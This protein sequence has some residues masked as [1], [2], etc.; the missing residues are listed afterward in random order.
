MEIEVWC[1]LASCCLRIPAPFHLVA[2]CDEKE[3]MAPGA[4]SPNC[5]VMSLQ[6]GDVVLDFVTG[7]GGHQEV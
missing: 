1:H 5:H 6:A 7:F 2:M 4:E 3:A